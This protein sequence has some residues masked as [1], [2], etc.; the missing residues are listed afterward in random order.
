MERAVV[1]SFA[2]Y[3]AASQVAADLML[4]GFAQSEIN[5][6]G[7]GSP[8]A[9]DGRDEGLEEL[10][11]HEPHGGEDAECAGSFGNPMIAVGSIA[12]ELLRAGEADPVPRL[13]HGLASM[14]VENCAAMRH[15]RAVAR[16]G[17][18][19]AL[20]LAQSRAALAEAV[21]C[22]H[23]AEAR[24]ADMP[25][26]IPATRQPYSIAARAFETGPELAE[27]APN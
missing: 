24:I 13:I 3:A 17:A 18:L 14:G 27:V 11:G 6:V 26:P 23:S 15:V 25:D 1:G 2:S 5:I 12:D 21:I 9:R 22:R 19:I 7:R 4:A 10:L 20:R 8:G 16:G